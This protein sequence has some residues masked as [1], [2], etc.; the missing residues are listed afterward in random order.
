MGGPIPDDV[1]DYDYNY[2]AK[3]FHFRWS[4][5]DPDLRELEKLLI[6]LSEIK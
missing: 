6:S 5:C 4:R 2:P 1:Y 3:D